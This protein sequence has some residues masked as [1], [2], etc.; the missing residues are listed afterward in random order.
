[1]KSIS[2]SAERVLK[3]PFRPPKINLAKGKPKTEPN[4]AKRSPRPSDDEE[5]GCEGKSPETS[6]Q[7]APFPLTT[8]P[9]S[10]ASRSGRKS[11]KLH[12]PFK[13]PT[14]KTDVSFDRSRA[15][16]PAAASLPADTDSTIS[17]PKKTSKTPRPVGS[18]INLAPAKP[19]S[20]QPRGPHAEKTKIFQ[21]ENKIRHLQAAFRLIENED[22]EQETEAET[23]MWLMAGRD[24]A[25]KVFNQLPKPDQLPGSDSS[26]ASM[27]YS[28]GFGSWG[29]DEELPT[30]AQ[31]GYGGFGDWA[32]PA[33]AAA[34]RRKVDAPS[35]PGLTD[36]QRAVLAEARSNDEGDA[37]DEDGNLLF[38]DGEA[39]DLDDI[40]AARS[41][42]ADT[43]RGSLYVSSFGECVP[44]A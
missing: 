8:T 11:A 1:V 39:I 24:V 10:G 28:G 22:K 43:G 33:R 15:P 2:E 41:S 7:L 26:L 6:P 35:Y 29:W 25:E 17:K 30:P 9:S 18:G 3:K 20:K 31:M 21:L 42:R 16:S 34:P 36:E 14:R 5:G 40:V 37:V 13:T 38:G 44:P 23:E 32:R 12:K 19:P 27:G 4:S